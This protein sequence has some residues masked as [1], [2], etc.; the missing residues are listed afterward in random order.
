[1]IQ[2]TKGK[3]YPSEYN[4]IIADYLNNNIID[5]RYFDMK[6]INTHREISKKYDINFYPNY[7]YIN[8]VTAKLEP[9]FLEK[10]PHLENKIH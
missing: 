6:V 8:P 7:F 9:I 2:S 5:S 3:I 1:M 4:N 10:N